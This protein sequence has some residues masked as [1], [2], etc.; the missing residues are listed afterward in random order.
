R[1]EVLEGMGPFLGGG[2]MIREVHV[3]RSTYAPP[4]QRFEAGTPPIAEAIALGEAASYLMEIGMERVFAHD[5]ALLE[6]ALKRLAEVPDLKVYGPKG[7]DRGG[8]IPFTLGRLHAHDLATF[9]DQEGIAVR[10]G[11]HCAQPLH[12]KLGLAATARASFYLYNTFEEVDRFVE[13][14]LRIHTRYRAWL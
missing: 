6:Y 1:Y 9:L 8:V 7:E 10:A 3:D 12:R 2:E 11:H 5:R 13:A 4:P 14:L